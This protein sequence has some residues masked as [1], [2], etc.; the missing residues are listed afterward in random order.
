MAEAKR[1]VAAAI[2]GRTEV[3]RSF[4][5]RFPRK[6]VRERAPFGKL[7]VKIEVGEEKAGISDPLLD[8]YGRPVAYDFV[9]PGYSHD[10]LCLR[11]PSGEPG[12]GPRNAGS[13]EDFP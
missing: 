3:L 11:V 9:S 2:A 8:L 1:K 10:D 7:F 5:H 12:P 4:L 6:V 13:I